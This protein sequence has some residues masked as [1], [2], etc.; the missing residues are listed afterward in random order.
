MA[1]QE[2]ATKGRPRP[3]TVVVDGLGHQLLAGSRLPAQEHG[4]V[5]AGDA[6]DRLVHVLHARV[7]PDERAELAHLLQPPPEPGHLLGQSGGGHRPL[8]EQQHLVKVEGL[9]QVVVGALLHGLDGRVHGAVGRHHHHTG[10]ATHLA[11]ALQ[12]AEPI[13][14]RHADVE[15]DEVEGLRLAGADGGLTVGDRG[16]VVAGLTQPFLQDPAQAVLVVS[17][18]DPRRGHRAMGR[19]QV[20]T[21]PRPSVESTWMAP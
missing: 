14:A 13:E 18:E 6:A 1:A 16:D 2:T 20:T 3:A 15:E 5:G 10:V 7:P 21:V 4:D 19:K 12:H 9:G 17:D 11:Q 8:R